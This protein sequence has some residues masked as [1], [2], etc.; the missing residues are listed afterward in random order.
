MQ[1]ITIQA[2]TLTVADRQKLQLL[3]V[4]TKYRKL[5]LDKCYTR[6]LRDMWPENYPDRQAWQ[7]VHRVWHL[8]INDP[9]ILNHLEMALDAE[10]IAKQWS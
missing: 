2:N 1:Q 4:K 6:M 5:G 8:Q 10:K 9:E 3:I 7:R